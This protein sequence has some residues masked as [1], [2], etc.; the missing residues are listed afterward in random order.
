MLVLQRHHGK[1][2]RYAD[3]DANQKS[4]IRE[5]LS[6]FGGTTDYS[7]MAAT[8]SAHYTGNHFIENEDD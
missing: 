7:H 5:L 3:L 8:I 1:D 2:V 4:R 6:Q